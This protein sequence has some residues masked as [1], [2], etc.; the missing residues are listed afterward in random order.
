MK[1]E[2]VEQEHC[3]V[4]VQAQERRYYQDTHITGIKTNS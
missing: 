3:S 2:R 1:R 4:N